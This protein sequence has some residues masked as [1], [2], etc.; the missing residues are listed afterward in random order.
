[1][2]EDTSSVNSVE[3]V[4]AQE[5]SQT[6]VVGS[7]PV[8]VEGTSGNNNSNVGVNVGSGDTNVS[9]TVNGDNTVVF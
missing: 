7:A 3:S 8:N 6:T 9:A 4:A 2:P 1:M 5:K